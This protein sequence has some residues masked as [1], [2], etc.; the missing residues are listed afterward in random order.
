ALLTTLEEQCP[1]LAAP[2]DRSDLRSARLALDIATRE[3]RTARYGWIPTLDVVGEFRAFHVI[4]AIQQ[5]ATQWALG[6]C[7]HGPIYEGGRIGADRRI[8]AARKSAPRAHLTELTRDAELEVSRAK[9]AVSVA[10]ANLELG[11]KMRDLALE[12]MNVA[13]TAF[14]HGTATGL[15]LIDAARVWKQAELDL[16]VREFEH[17]DARISALLALSRCADASASRQRSSEENGPP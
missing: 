8:E 2:M 5:R 6:A 16:A 11:R 17:V 10:Q 12:T 3:H 1:S 15:D 4:G 7:L 9:R 14:V 13:R